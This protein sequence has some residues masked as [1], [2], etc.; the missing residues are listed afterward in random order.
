MGKNAGV[1]VEREIPLPV[2]KMKEQTMEVSRKLSILENLEG[3]RYGFV[4][5]YSTIRSVP[6]DYPT[7]LASRY[8]MFYRRQPGQ[9]CCFKTRLVL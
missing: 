3:T 4:G 2:I 1:S 8:W 7:R 6:E 9:N 5:K